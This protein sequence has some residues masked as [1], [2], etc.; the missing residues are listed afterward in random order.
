MM[1]NNEII[2]LPLPSQLH[3]SFQLS[4]F[5]LLQYNDIDDFTYML[6]ETKKTIQLYRETEDLLSFNRYMSQNTINLA[7]EQINIITKQIPEL[8]IPLNMDMNKA[9]NGYLFFPNEFI[10]GYTSPL[11]L[12]SK[13]DIHYKLAIS[14]NYEY[15]LGYIYFAKL[16]KTSEIFEETAQTYFHFVLQIIELLPS[17][18]IKGLCY[19]HLDM[20]D[21]AKIS[22]QQ[23]FEENHPLFQY[24]YAQ[25]LER[26]DDIE[27]SYN[28]Y[29][30]IVSSYPNAL[31]SL[32]Y[33]QN[34]NKKQ[35][36]YFYQATKQDAIEG[37]VKIGEL[38][39]NGYVYQ[40]EE[41][42][43]NT[44]S[45]WYTQAANKGNINSLL[46]F[47]N[48]HE[49]MNEWENALNV[50]NK[51]IDQGFLIGYLKKGQIFENQ[52][53][54]EEAKQTYQSALWFGL[55]KLSNKNVLENI[56]KNKYKHFDQLIKI[57]ESIY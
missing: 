47:G 38:I 18:S 1:N 32:A 30:E 49:E 36:D 7:I 35:F 27:L 26:D 53:L 12:F 52:G 5:K 13:I 44:A 8:I 50:Y 17:S 3:N 29:Q 24:L 45:Y 10:E 37:Y 43:K 25:I 11:I 51:I 33:Y 54:D 28:I 55:H 34:S 46:L 48:Y 22:L 57:I 41:N 16:L 23:N 39:D 21:K 20:F 6:K 4:Y 40:E 42:E 56:E 2:L 15:P 31:L 19:F 9:I 14:A